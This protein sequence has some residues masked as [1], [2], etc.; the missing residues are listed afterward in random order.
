MLLEG[1]AEFR[2]N[3]EGAPVRMEMERG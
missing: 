3:E 1:T 2:S